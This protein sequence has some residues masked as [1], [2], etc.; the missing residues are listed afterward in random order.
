MKHFSRILLSLLVLLSVAC[1]TAQSP[2]PE[3]PEG[4]QLRLDAAIERAIDDGR[5]VGGVLYVESGDSKYEKVY[6]LRAVTPDEEVMTR[7]TIFDVAS[8][9]KSMAATPAIMLLVERGLVD[10]EAPVR[11]YVP[12]FEGG[13][14]DEAT[15]RQLL[16]HF[17][18]LRP[19]LDLDEPWSGYETAIDLIMLEELVNRPGAAFR[20]SDIGFELIGEIVHRVSGT[21]LDRFVEREVYAPLGMDD[22]G[23]TP[24]ESRRPRIAPTEIVEG[25]GLLRGIVHDPTARRMGGLAGHAGLFTTLDDIIRYVHMLRNGG[26]LDG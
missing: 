4:T 10:L 14:R 23:F 2:P 17:S 20:Y 26:E 3:I 16:T 21:P 15:V 7:D 5:I 18:G 13:W 9:T 12:E 6:G 19:D 25:A 8:I 24:D 11:R 22:S 1:G